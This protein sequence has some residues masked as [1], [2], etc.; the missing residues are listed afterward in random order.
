MKAAVLEKYGEV[1]Q[2]K[3][4]PTPE[5]SS[6]SEVLMEV[7]A[8]AL[9]NFDKFVAAGKSYVS[10][11]HLPAVVGSDAVG[12]LPD[13][14]SVYARANGTFAEKAIIDSSKSI[15]LPDGIDWAT[16]AALPNA[17][18]GAGLA[19]KRRAG[20]KT[21]DIVLINGGTGVTGKIAIQ[22]ARYYGAAKVFVTGF[23]EKIEAEKG[24]IGI[25]ALISTRENDKVFLEKL[26]QLNAASPIT[27][28]L[29]YLWGHSAEL[30]LQFLM[31]SDGKFMEQF[32]RFIQIGSLAGDEIK[33]SANTLRSS[34]V[35]IVG[36]GVGSHSA[37]DYRYF[38]RELLP[39]AFRLAARGK[40]K[41]ETEEGNLKDISSLW[42]KPANGKR[43]VVKI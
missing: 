18:L 40:I 31:G 39:E 26:R 43:L 2:Y 12:V 36:S 34:K 17:V 27:V 16:A 7:K 32:T 23:T 1:P 30:I 20:I 38:N 21:G 29:D 8:A 25:D 19:L 37:D 13:G 42:N 24:A 9:K 3:E 15:P 10:Y 11:G 33:L 35:N 22:L 4:F 6:T 28:V 14:T 5:P 41:I